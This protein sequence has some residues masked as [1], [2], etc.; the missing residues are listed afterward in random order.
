MKFKKKLMNWAE[1]EEGEQELATRKRNL[2][3]LE[4]IDEGWVKLKQDADLESQTTNARNE[5]IKRSSAS[6]RTQHLNAQEQELIQQKEEL[7]PV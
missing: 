1:I 6:R 2:T 7:Q 5:S 3:M 4:Q